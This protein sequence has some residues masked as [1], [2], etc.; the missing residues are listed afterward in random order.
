[1]IIRS[2]AVGSSI[3][4]ALAVVLYNNVPQYAAF[5]DWQ[6]AHPMLLLLALPAGVVAAL[7]TD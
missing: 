5:M 2:I 3:G 1:M 6:F 4:A 7:V